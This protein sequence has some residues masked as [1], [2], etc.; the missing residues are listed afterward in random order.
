MRANLPVVEEKLRARNMD[1]AVVMGN[2]SQ[3][4]THRRLAITEAESL[5]ANRKNL[6]E[7]FGRLKREGSD[8][9]QL[10][11][12]LNVFKAKVEQLEALRR[13]C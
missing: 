5:A 9:G 3:L 1:P 8:T 10:T 6:S 12:Q 7:T 2:F 4:D 11:A 13:R